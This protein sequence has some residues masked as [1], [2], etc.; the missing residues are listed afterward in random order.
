M[1]PVGANVPEQVY[2]PPPR[3]GAPGNLTETQYG[4]RAAIGKLVQS[5]Q[6]K[7]VRMVARLL[8][9]HMRTR[10]GALVLALA[11]AA[12]AAFVVARVADVGGQDDLPPE[13][14]REWFEA[15]DREEAKPRFAGGVVNGVRVLAPGETPPPAPCE[16]PE[17]LLFQPYKL[18]IGTPY[19]IIPPF[20]PEGGEERIGAENQ[21][22]ASELCGSRVVAAARAWNL[23]AGVLEVF[24]ML[25]PEPYTSQIDASSERVMAGEV[26]S[27]PALFVHPI[28]K[29]GRG[30]S[31]IIFAE[32]VPEGF[33]V[34][35]IVSDGIPF[36]VVI[37][38]AE[39]LQQ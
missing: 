10:I 26:G 12:I 18:A 21:G 27:Q 37:E 8:P 31:R 28:L 38:F 9:K 2:Y 39:G 32:P 7:G 23:P 30:P 35:E 17:L 11:V 3:I 19:E 36:D 15:V 4:K 22:G 16:V 33:I 5:A 25:R 6:R 13:A 20:I 24:R 14:D 29:D 1:A 34:T